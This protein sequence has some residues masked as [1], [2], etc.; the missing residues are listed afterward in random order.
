MNEPTQIKVYATNPHPCSYLEARVATTAFV[1][2]DLPM[3]SRLYSLL[4]DNGFRRSGPHVYKPHCAACRAC[5]PARLSVARFSPNRTQR[6]LLRRNSDLTATTLDDGADLGVLYPLYQRYI[7]ARHADGD[8]FPPSRSQ[9]ESFLSREWGIT[10]F[11][12]FWLDGELAAVAV[13]DRLQRG[14]SAVYTFFDPDLGRR[15][16]GVWAILQQI[17]QTRRL[18]LDYLYLGYWIEESPKMAYKGQFRGLE[19][20]ADGRWIAATTGE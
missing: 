4:S 12:C 17:E 3:D 9:F 6:R 19:T 1:D 15:S 13:T 18:G 16:L 11:Q 8:M 2:P 10:R 5:L 7:C 14:L 20:F